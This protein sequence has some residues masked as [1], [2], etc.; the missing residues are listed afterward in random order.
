MFNPK[1]FGTAMLLA[2]VGGMIILKS[3][4]IGMEA[5]YR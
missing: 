4:G 2:A 1:R 3:I 5:F